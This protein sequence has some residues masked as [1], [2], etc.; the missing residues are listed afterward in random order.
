MSLTEPVQE[1]L[2]IAPDKK[3][4]ILQVAKARFLHYGVSKTTT[5]DIAEDLGIS[6]SNLYLYF[7]NKREII[8]AIAEE[9]RSEQ[10]KTDQE[11]LSDAT[12]T[13]PQKLE[14]LLVKKF[15]QLKAFRT[16]SP[17]GAEL[18]AYLV[19]EYPERLTNWQNNLENLIF[20]V[21]DEGVRQGDFRIGDVR[22]GAHMLRIA[23][24]Q[25]FLP[26]HIQLPI[27]ATEEELVAFVHW[28][29]SLIS[30]P[31]P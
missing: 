25:F 5:R 31:R 26:A 4:R 30:P 10:D 2:D 14:R 28:H 11:V 24:T 27:E 20:T 17:K 19:Q 16:E 9:C 8:L 15:R 18:I 13:P 23:L 6:V 22:H 21:L 1:P 3:S 7:E 12:L 29:L